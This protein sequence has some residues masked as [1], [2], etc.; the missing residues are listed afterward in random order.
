MG[1]HWSI[2]AA[3]VSILVSFAVNLL[4]TR[5]GGAPPAG[6]DHDHGHSHGHGHDHDHGHAHDPLEEELPVP[7]AAHSMHGVHS[8]TVDQ[9]LGGI[10]GQGG[11]VFDPE[12]VAEYEDEEHTQVMTA[13]EVA[14]RLDLASDTVTYTAPADADE[15]VV[16]ESDTL[17]IS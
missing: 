8:S 10:L 12:P 4:W 13:D 17:D 16:E 9:G 3:G 7:H 14:N 2:G 5:L 1:L 6:H 15:K 11:P